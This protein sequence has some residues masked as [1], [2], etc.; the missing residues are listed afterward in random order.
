MW[1]VTGLAT[2]LF[3]LTQCPMCKEAMEADAKTSGDGM[4]RAF[5]DSIYLMVAAPYVMLGVGIWYVW[6]STRKQQPPTP[7]A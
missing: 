1:P 3:L 4:V 5:A 7:D 2:A 6:R